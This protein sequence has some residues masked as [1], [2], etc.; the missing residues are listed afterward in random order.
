[1]ADDNSEQAYSASSD[2]ES[3]D[4]KEE[5][6]R[7]EVKEVRKLS[8]KD[9]N[10]IRLWR[11][12]VT[13][14]VL[15]TAVAVTLTTYALLQQ[16]EHENFLNAVRIVQCP[17]AIALHE[18]SETGGSSVSHLTISTNIVVIRPV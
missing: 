1:M 11:F 4:A 15:L 14:V 10:R 17:N 3:Y 9:T 8:S 16:Q 13:A 5:V 7:D 2:D 6:D 12:V 18:Q